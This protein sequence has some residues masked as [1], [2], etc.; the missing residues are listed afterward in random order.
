[1]FTIYIAMA[2]VAFQMS[3]IRLRRS[4]SENLVGVNFIVQYVQV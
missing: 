1:M 3:V 4:G 2:C